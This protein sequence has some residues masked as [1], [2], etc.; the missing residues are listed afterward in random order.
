MPKVPLYFWNLGKN[1]GWTPTTPVAQVSDKSTPCLDGCGT[2]SPNLRYPKSLDFSGNTN[3]LHH[4]V[5]NHLVKFQCFSA[6]IYWKCANFVF[7]NPFS[8]H[9]WT[10]WISGTLNPQFQWKYILSALLNLYLN[11]INHLLKFQVFSA[12]VYWKKVRFHIF[13]P[14]FDPYFEILNLCGILKATISVEI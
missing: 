6:R 2:I 4:K 11:V 5:I 1:L 10:I 8:F 3:Y 9:F 7:F 12:L 13:D 14:I